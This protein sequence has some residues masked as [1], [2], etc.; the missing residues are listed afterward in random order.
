MNDGKRASLTTAV[1]SILACI[2]AASILTLCFLFPVHCVS[3]SPEFY[4]DKWDELDIKSYTEMDEASLEKALSTLLS[5][6][7]G[8][9]DTP[10]VEVTVAG[11]PRLLYNQR[12]LQHL[13]DVQVLFRDGLL[14]E[15]YA[16][17]LGSFAFLALLWFGEPVAPKKQSAAFVAAGIAGLALVLLVAVAA[18][19]NFDSFWRGFH[20]MSFENDLWLLDPETDWLIRMFPEEF[21]LSAVRRI[22][23]YIALFTVC[24]IGIGILIRNRALNHCHLH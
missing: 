24:S 21:F 23:S 22:S 18:A 10:Q 20:L 5:Y 15:K 1:A 2:L 8:K 9:L 19:L 3:L 7:K 17:V 11:R 12:E 4:R 6:L 13:K 16:T 14:T